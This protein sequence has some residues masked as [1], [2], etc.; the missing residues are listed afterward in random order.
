[1][2]GCG[3]SRWGPRVNERGGYFGGGG[4]LTHQLKPAGLSTVKFKSGFAGYCG[5]AERGVPGLRP[6]VV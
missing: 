1:M 2:A 4:A 6:G 5:Q 3:C